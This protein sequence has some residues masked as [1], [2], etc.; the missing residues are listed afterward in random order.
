M[1]YNLIKF[2]KPRLSERYKSTISNKIS[3]TKLFKLP[4]FK[5]FDTH[6]INYTPTKILR[7]LILVRYYSIHYVYTNNNIVIYIDKYMVLKTK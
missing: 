1:G 3:D 7:I 4:C 5:N 6:I 2:L